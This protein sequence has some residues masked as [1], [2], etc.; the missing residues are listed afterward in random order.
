ME[1]IKLLMT[2][3]VLLPGIVEVKVGGLEEIEQLISKGNLKRTL[4]PTAMNQFSSRSH[5]ILQLRVE[6]RE[7]HGFVIFLIARHN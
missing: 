7:K 3:G 1:K 4:A 2:V 6:A 5:A